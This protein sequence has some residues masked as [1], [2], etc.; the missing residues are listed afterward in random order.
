M[1]G[2]MSPDECERQAEAAMSKALVA[3]GEDRQKWMRVAIAWLHLARNATDR[4]RSAKCPG[5]PEAE[6]AAD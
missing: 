6:G 2:I 5:R 3:T 4:D 1:M